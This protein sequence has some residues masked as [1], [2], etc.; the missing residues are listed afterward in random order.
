MSVKIT[1][2]DDDAA[3]ELQPHIKAPPRLW[4]DLSFLPL[5]K[6]AKVFAA[7]RGEELVGLWLV[8]LTPEGALPAAERPIR[9]FP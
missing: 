9:L 6:P 8:P 3:H 1:V 5:L 7:W 2:H 4:Q